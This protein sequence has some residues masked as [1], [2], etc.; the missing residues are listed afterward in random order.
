[1]FDTIFIGMSGL[2]GYSQGL[3]VISN[4]VT[5]LNT[6]GFKSSSLQFTDAFYQQGGLSG[7]YTQGAGQQQYGTGLSTLATQLNFKAGETRT[8]GNA[9]DLAISGDGLFVLQDKETDKQ[10]FTRA[11]QFE[12]DKDGALVTTTSGKYVMGHASGNNSGDLSRITLSDL[13]INAAH[14]TSLV[15]LTGN[16]SSTATDFDVSNVKLIDAVGGE[17][18]VRLNFR[19]RSSSQAGGWTVTVFDGETSVA[20]GDIL[21]TGSGPDPAHNSLSFSYTPAGGTAFDVKLDLSKGVTSFAA[22]S[23][24]TLAV[25]SQDGYVAGTLSD[26]TFDADGKLA[27]NY[28]N[29]QKTKGASLALATFESNLGLEQAGGGELVATGAQKARI[30]TPGEQ[31]VGSIQ[32]GQVELSNVDLSAEFSDLIIMQ[33]GY[34]ASSHMISTANDMIQELFD[35]KGHR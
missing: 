32:S 29:G 24:S 1:M 19:S 34:Q 2:Q 28:T 8:T 7:G 16:L 3:K 10:S 22:G 5:N 20:S 13:R 15:S 26:V 27:L 6:P 30:G 25:G 18:A 31:G 14:A 11:G 33:R 12:F 23:T 35:L 21:F 9:L 4:N 17:H